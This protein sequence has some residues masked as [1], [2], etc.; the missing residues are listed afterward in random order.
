MG[1]PKGTPVGAQVDRTGYVLECPL[2]PGNCTA[3]QGSG[4]GDDRRLYDVDGEWHARALR[5][6]V[7]G[8]WALPFRCISNLVH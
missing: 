2:R 3:L 6:S 5:C 4:M 1:V 7:G 8:L